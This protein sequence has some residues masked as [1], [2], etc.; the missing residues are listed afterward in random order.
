MCVRMVDSSTRSAVAISRFQSPRA[1]SSRTCRSGG[2]SASRPADRRGRVGCWAMR[3]ITRRVTE[4]ESR[5]SPAVIV[6]MP[7][8]S[9]SGRVR[10]TR[11]P[12]AQTRRRRRPARGCPDQHPHVGRGAR[13]LARRR[14]PVDVR[15][16]DVHQHDVRREQPGSLDGPRSVDA[17][18]AISISGSAERSPA[19]PAHMRSSSW[20][21]STRVTSRELRREG[22]RRPETCRGSG[23]RPSCRRAGR[24]ARASG[25]TRAR[26]STSLGS[27]RARGC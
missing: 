17:S 24:R 3:S 2:V 4:G 15:H 6:W 8:T 7:A 20:A 23:P 11:K 26:R 9:S 18:P 27:R 19:N 13:Q 5:E 1:T 10:L 25:S 14:D 12:E 16:A 21:I 22:G